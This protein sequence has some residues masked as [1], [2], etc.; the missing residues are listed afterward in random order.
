MGT[1]TNNTS[2]TQ[3]APKNLTPKAQS[4][5]K[6]SARLCPCG[7]HPASLTAV[8][9]CSRMTGHWVVLDYST[10]D[11]AYTLRVQF[12]VIPARSDLDSM[13]HNHLEQLLRAIQVTLGVDAVPRLDAAL[14]QMVG[15]SVR[16]SVAHRA[17]RR[18]VKRAQITGW[19]AA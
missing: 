3:A 8:A 14:K 11:P 4:S 18:G 9:V 16:I 10:V 5:A 7:Q 1:K 17:D 2:P 6:H 12:L 19:E 13:C 15:K